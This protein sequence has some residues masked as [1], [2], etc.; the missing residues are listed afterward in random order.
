MRQDHL[1]IIL[2]GET[3]DKETAQA[4]M[5]AALTSYGFYYITCKLL[6]QLQDL[7]KWKFLLILIGA[8]IIGVVAQRL[9]RKVC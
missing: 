2:V 1:D 9:V 6:L 3:R 8:S 5:E 4:A 7:L